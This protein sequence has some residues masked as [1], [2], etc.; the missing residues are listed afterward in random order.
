MKLAFSPCCVATVFVDQ[1]DSAT[2]MVLAKL[3][4]E[5]QNGKDFNCCGYPV[6]GFDYKAYIHL[7][8]RNLALAEEQEAELLTACGCCYSSLKHVENLLKRNDSLRME[9]NRT[10]KKEG[11]RYTGTIAVRHLL[12]IILSDIGIPE[13][14]VRLKKTLGGLK[15]ATHYGCHLLRPGEIV[16]FDNP[17]SP[18][19][20]DLLVEATGA[21][22][23]PWS[24]KPDCCG[25]PL[26]G[27][28][29]ALALGLVRRKLESAKEAE[30][31]YLCSACPWCHLQFEKAQE[32][33]RSECAL[34]LRIP[35][36]TYA[37]LLGLCLGIDEESLGLGRRNAHDLHSHWAPRVTW[38]GM[39]TSRQA[40]D[41]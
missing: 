10:L 41:H 35:S 33:L 27:I 28:N 2:V 31:D 30:A 17:F 12:E 5:V 11:L 24:A 16:G 4:I 23:I 36:L 40:P 39:E 13:L 9:V 38:S 8:T 25:A 14:R 26:V 6:K 37:H 1:Y 3:G 18:V 22:S 20:F 7:A 21:E 15:I 29:D 34:D 19:K 32:I